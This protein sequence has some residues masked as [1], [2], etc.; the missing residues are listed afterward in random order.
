MYYVGYESCYLKKSTKRDKWLLVSL[1]ICY[2]SI[3]DNTQSLNVIVT[4]VL[5]MWTWYR[6][7]I[8]L[9]KKIRTK[10]DKWLLVSLSMFYCS[11]INNTQS[12]NVIVMSVLHM[13]KRRMKIPEAEVIYRNAVNTMP[14]RKRT[15]TV[16]RNNFWH[17]SLHI[18]IWMVLILM[19]F[20]V[21][22]LIFISFNGVWYQVVWEGPWSES[23]VNK[24]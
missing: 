3:I 4:S 19:K 5:H 7:W 16:R 18:Y 1:N 2:C 13:C 20:N 23:G 14:K 10:R 12:L 22:F 11:I 17:F 9:L 24:R 6:I 15:N 8:L 21:L